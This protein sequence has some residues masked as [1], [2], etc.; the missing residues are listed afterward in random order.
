MLLLCLTG[1]PLIF[2]HEIDHALGYSVEPPVLPETKQRANLNR[3]VADARTRKPG[4]VVEYLVGDPDQP[5]LWHIRMGETMNAPEISAFYSYDART[6][7]FLQEYPLGQGVMNVLLRLHVDLFA[8]LPG[9]LFLGFMGVL[10]VF[11]LLSGTILYGFY[12]RRLRFGTVR[13][14]RSTR[15]KWLDLHNLLGIATLVWLLVVSITGV[16]NT[17]SEP[18]FNHWQ[19]TELAAMM[20]PYHGGKALVGE[21]AVQQAVNFAYQSEPGMTLRFM[22]FP[23]NRFAGPRHFVAFM[24][25]T[26][27]WA[28]KLLKPLLIDAQTGHVVDRRDLPGY[29][30]ALLVSQP[31]HFGDYGGLPLKILWALLDIIAIIVLISG[32]YLWLKKRHLSF[33]TRFALFPAE[34]DSTA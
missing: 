14:H 19:S 34:Q 23:G 27:P 4:H 2:A 1:L 10:L 21:P 5:N 32:L 31:L 30:S 12:M 11:S 24:Q 22:A 17:L 13:S 16:I 18:I 15:I 33:E 8:G 9:M 25:G 29:V 26:T 7:A 3:I 28:S 20:A 6:G